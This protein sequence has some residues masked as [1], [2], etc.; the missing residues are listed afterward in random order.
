MGLQDV[1]RPSNAD[2]LYLIA[3]Q[4]RI[5]N[6]RTG[7]LERRYESMLYPPESQSMTASEFRAN[8]FSAR[9]ETANGP[10]VLPPTVR[11]DETAE[12]LQQIAADYHG[13]QPRDRPMRPVSLEA[14]PLPPGATAAASDHEPSDTRSRRRSHA[15]ARTEQSSGTSDSAD[16]PPGDSP[17]SD[18]DDSPDDSP[19]DR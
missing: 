11:G 3:V 6:P 13:E 12:T 16:D 19:E 8:S 2:L 9:D 10:A 17:P 1:E 7:K 4:L 15:T 18:P 14:P 5:V